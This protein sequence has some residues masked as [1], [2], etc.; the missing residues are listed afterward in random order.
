[1]W[2]RS[3]HAEPAQVR[4]FPMGSLPLAQRQGGEA[5]FGEPECGPQVPGRA[6]HAALVS[7]VRYWVAIQWV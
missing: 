3:P 6:V 2:G 4:Q 5:E 1:M 7:W